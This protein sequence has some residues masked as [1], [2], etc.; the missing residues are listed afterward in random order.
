MSAYRR[1][2][3]VGIALA[4]AVPS[5]SRCCNVGGVSSGA[6]IAAG[7]ANGIS[8]HETHAMGG[9]CCLFTFVIFIDLGYASN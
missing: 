2:G 5:A 3:K 6:F 9:L 1:R 7:L 8:P 4:G